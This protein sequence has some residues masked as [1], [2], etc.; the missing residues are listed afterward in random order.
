MNIPVEFTENDISRIARQVPRI[1]RPLREGGREEQ[2][3]ALSNLVQNALRVY[4]QLSSIA[5][6]ED[7]ITVTYRNETYTISLV[8]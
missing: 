6:N 3:K 5:K 4:L 1:A 2:E 8:E 7:E